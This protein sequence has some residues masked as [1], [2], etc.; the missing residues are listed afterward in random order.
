MFIRYGRTRETST[1]LTNMYFLYI[2][3]IH[4]T[5]HYDVGFNGGEVKTP[6]LDAL[7]ADGVILER[8]YAYQFCSPTVCI[9]VL[10]A[11]RCCWFH[12]YISAAIHFLK[13]PPFTAGV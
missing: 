1:T 4:Y 13:A 10:T 8:Y 7:A 6:T 5:R 3:K 9:G 11:Y 2:S 12:K